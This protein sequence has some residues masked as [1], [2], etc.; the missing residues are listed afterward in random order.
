M[1]GNGAPV[2]APERVTAGLEV[3]G[4]SFSSDGARLAYSKGRWIA[5]V[6]RVPILEDRPA[7]WADAQQVTFEQAFIESVSV[8]P[9][10]QRLLYS[11]DRTG[12][13]DLWV[14]PIGGGM[15]VPLTAGP[16][17]D[18]APSWSPDGRQITF[19]SYRTGDREIWTMPAAGGA[20]TQI[21][22]SKGLDAGPRWSPGGHEIAFR[23]ERTGNSEIWA[24]TVDGS[25]S[26]QLTNDPAG[27]YLETWSP[28]GRWLA[29]VSTRT[30][31]SQIWRVPSKGGEPE[32]LT[33][34]PGWAPRWS[35]DGAH[36][37]FPGSDE[38]TGNLWRFSFNTRS[39]HPVTSLSGKRG[40]LGI[41]QPDTDGRYLYFTWR[42]D[43][44]DIWVMDV[45]GR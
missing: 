25:R 42:D 38:R 34:G 21:T 5:N 20:A 10:G 3:R 40:R 14:M 37:F 23:S 41:M 31:R 15:G 18:W 7:T 27:D 24:T 11:S 22:R 45:V 28:D 29:F 1:S 43:V 6:W 44:G 9:D 36:I 17:P 19:Y 12:N 30:G 39:E 13:Q 33:R 2:G 8:S 4:A 35:R 32:L 26:R 16:D